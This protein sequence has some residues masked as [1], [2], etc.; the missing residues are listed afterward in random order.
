MNKRTSFF[1]W[2]MSALLA[3]A[4]LSGGVTRAAD[5]QKSPAAK[6]A[7]STATLPA[8]ANATEVYGKLTKEIE[9]L[10][11]Q[12]VS[13][14]APEDQMRLYN[15][16][17]GKLVAFRTKYPNTPEA[18]DAGFQ[19][20]ALNFGMQKYELSAQLLNEYLGKVTASVP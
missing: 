10:S 4:S 2:T 7:G 12:V 14:N 3:G 13:S 6:P 11:K 19:L 5:A 20:G 1:A 18:N 15:Q 8:G 17:Q 16:I 9:E